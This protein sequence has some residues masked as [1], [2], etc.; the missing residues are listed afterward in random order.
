MT[1]MITNAGEDDIPPGLNVKTHGRKGSDDAY[2]LRPEDGDRVG[3][4]E[5]RNAPRS[6]YGRSIRPGRRS[7]GSNEGM[8]AYHC[9]EPE[10]GLRPGWQY[11]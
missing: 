4:G 6:S 3:S 11:Q 5:G 10:P 1:N 2:Q 8:I 9:N 7:E